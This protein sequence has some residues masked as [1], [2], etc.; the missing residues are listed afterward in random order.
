MQIGIGLGLTLPRKAGS[1]APDPAVVAYAAAV[2]SAGG[3]LSGAQSSALNTFVMSA[4][5]TGVWSKLL[6]VGVFLGGTLASAAV[7]LKYPVTQNCVLNS[8]VLG[9]LTSLGLKGNGS[10]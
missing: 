8:F 10:K 2:T 7:K 3:S 5:A 4:K 1:S 9:D 6:E